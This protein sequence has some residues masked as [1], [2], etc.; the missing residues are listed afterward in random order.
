MFI[1]EARWIKGALAESSLEP[2]GTVLDV[3]SS[4]MEF[5]TVIQPHIHEF[6]HKP[7]IDCGYKL[8]FLDIKSDEGIDIKVDLSSSD[9]PEG[10]FNETYDLVICCNILE[11][12]KDRDLFIRNLL[13]FTRRGTML[14]LTVPRL[15][16]KHND[17]IDTLYRPSID[18]LA[19][20]IQK[21]VELDILLGE[22]LV[23]SDKSYYQKKPGRL[24]D[25]ILMRQQRL[26]A[27]W[28]LKPFRWR[29]T[30]MLIRIK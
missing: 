13:R 30:C 25:Y 4:N 18:E 6:I 21:Y 7:L 3:G 22:E 28:Y 8:R 2:P 1:E 5:R 16:P 14:M 19:D 9:L 24:L 20:L 17:P 10:I 23:I 11:H 27:R 29:V 26:Y 15:Y 12:V